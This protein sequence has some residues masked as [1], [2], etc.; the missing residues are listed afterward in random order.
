MKT[1]QERLEALRNELRAEVTADVAVLAR[2]LDE[3]GEDTTPSQHPADVASD[4]Y[5]REELVTQ[6]A[7]LRRGLREVEDALARVADGT[8]GRCTD[9]G[10]A[11]AAARL[12]VLP[13]AARCI[14]CQRAVDRQA[15][16]HMRA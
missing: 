7:T 4:L 6:E 9:C 15:R 10:G 14:T 5:A 12:E 16:S 2:D 3:K 8:Y 11:I 1:P 13:E